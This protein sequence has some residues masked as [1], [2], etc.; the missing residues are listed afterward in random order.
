MYF[1]IKGCLVFIYFIIT[2]MY[3]FC[4]FFA[5]DQVQETSPSYT[6]FKILNGLFRLNQI[7]YNEIYIVMNCIY[8]VKLFMQFTSTFRVNLDFY[9][10]NSTLGHV[11][12]VFG[13]CQ[14]FQYL[15]HIFDLP[16]SDKK[17]SKYFCSDF[18]KWFSLIFADF[19]HN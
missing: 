6:T 7:R 17:C 9:P 10:L 8:I 18:L 11:V 16:H 19:G 2:W 5:M 1:T 15:P 13:W 14:F 4:Y 3:F 12:Y